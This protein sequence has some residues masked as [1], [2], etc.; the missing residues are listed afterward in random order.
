MPEL[1]TTSLIGEYE[2]ILL[3]GEPGTGK[4]HTAGTMPGPIYFLIVGLPN[5][6]KTLVGPTFRSQ[7]PGVVVHYDYVLEESGERGQF[8]NATAFDI[9]GDKLDAALEARRK[10]DLDFKTIVVENATTLIEVQMNKAMEVAYA[11]S[12]NQSATTL[13]KYREHG[14]K[15]IGDADYGGAQSLMDQFLSWLTT[16]VEANVV[17]VAHEHQDKTKDRETRLETIHMIRPSFIGKHRTEIPRLFDNVWRTTV[18]GG[19][20]NRAYEIQT[21]GDDKTLAKT[22]VGGVLP[23]SDRNVNLSEWMEL[24]RGVK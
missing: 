13:R 12:K 14:M 23:I 1:L 11:L 7:H 16:R 22:R 19:G 3:Y 5:E 17:L 15:I 21:V 8:E 18:A 2:K 20:R 9:A 6:I 10:G 4:T 24:M